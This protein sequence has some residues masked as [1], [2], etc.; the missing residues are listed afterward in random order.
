MGPKRAAWRWMKAFEQKMLLRF[1]LAILIW[2]LIDSINL[3]TAPIDGSLEV[4]LV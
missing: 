1:G 2:L 3:L 4:L